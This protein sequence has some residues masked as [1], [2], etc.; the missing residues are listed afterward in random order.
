M[1]TCLFD[2]DGV[3]IGK[4]YFSKRLADDFKIPEELIKPFFMGDLSYAPLGR[5]I[6]R[7]KLVNI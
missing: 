4:K 3:L 5:R 6:S 7:K 1:K 2:V